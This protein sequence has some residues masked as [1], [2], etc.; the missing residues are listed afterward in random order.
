M[1]RS[2]VG[3]QIEG[4]LSQAAQRGHKLR[5]LGL[6]LGDGRRL[7]ATDPRDRLG[8][9]SEVV[10]PRRERRELCPHGTGRR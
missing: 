6:E 1:R 3:A 10:S 7:P 5:H 2:D 4:A 8:V 9:G